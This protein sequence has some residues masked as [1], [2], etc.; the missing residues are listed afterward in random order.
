MLSRA[1]AITLN[2]ALE[3]LLALEKKT[4]LA[5]DADSTTVVAS[6]LL[7]LLRERSDWA[8]INQ[9]ITLLCTRRAQLT[10]VL[11]TVVKTAFGW[12]AETP[13]DETKRKL[14]DT[15]RT[16][17]AGK[18]VVELEHAR[19]TRILSQMHEREG[20]LNEAGDLL[21]EV[22]VET[23]GSMEMREKADFLLEQLRL[24]LVRQDRVRAEMVARKV[25][26]KVLQR[27]D[28][29]DLKLRFN[30]LMIRLHT[31]N[32]NFLE[33][34]RCYRNMFDTPSVQADREQWT[35]MLRR[36]VM[37]AVLAEFDSEVSDIL[38]RLKT[39]KK[40]VHLPTEKH[41][42]EL[43]TADELIHWPLKCQDEWL[44]DEVFAGEDGRKRW[45]ET[46][47]K[48]VVQHNIRTISK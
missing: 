4:R 5:A 47:H 40:L 8:A 25:N 48:R 31:M 24:C 37:F 27:D 39:E 38:H 44:A 28:M 43:F 12:L 6:A 32:S 34:C 7:K 16:V 21:Q 14:I 13:D 20:K 45:N 29:Q 33:I 46:V 42:L 30:E 15:I 19:T 23:I 41:A 11:M 26:I 36:V 1:Q 10:K 18:I 3:E 35:R 22:Q 2:A 9:H 17:S